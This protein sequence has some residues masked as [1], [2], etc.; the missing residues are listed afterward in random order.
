MVEK[1]KLYIKGTFFANKVL[2]C[3]DDD[4]I[5]QLGTDLL[6]LED[7]FHDTDS[8]SN[9]FKDWKDNMNQVR[10]EFGFKISADQFCKMRYISQTVH[11]NKLKYYRKI[12]DIWNYILVN[13]QVKWSSEK[14][15]FDKSCEIYQTRPL[16]TIWDIFGVTGKLVFDSSWLGN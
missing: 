7:V 14:Y 15:Y 8:R 12:L 13:F 5:L 3:F 2:F 9:L 6:T 11:Q 1:E 10:S 16:C 4:A